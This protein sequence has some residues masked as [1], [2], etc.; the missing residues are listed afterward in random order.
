[1]NTE[2]CEQTFV[3][4][5]VWDPEHGD[6]PDEI[7]LHLDE[8]PAC[9][10]RFNAR[11]LPWQPPETQAPRARPPRRRANGVLSVLAAAAAL[12]LFLSPARTLQHSAEPLAMLFPAESTLTFDEIVPARE[13][14]L[15]HGIDLEDEECEPADSE[16][17]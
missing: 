11:F 3:V 6:L 10:N 15:L 5:S 14:P 8:C 1:M 2:R 7:A 4:L 12:A 9:M 17:L 16:W 13:C